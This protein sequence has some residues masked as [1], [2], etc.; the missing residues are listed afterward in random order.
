MY[1]IV[2]ILKINRF[3]NRLPFQFNL[4]RKISCKINTDIKIIQQK[5][6]YFW[7]RI[8]LEHELVKL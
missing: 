4:Y 3:L 6:Q 1:Y 8:Y 2:T 5:T 7:V